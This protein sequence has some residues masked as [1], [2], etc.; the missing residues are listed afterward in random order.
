M[1]VVDLDIGK[2]SVHNE[3]IIYIYAIGSIL[4]VVNV[5]NMMISFLRSK[6]YEYFTVQEGTDRIIL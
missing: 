6:K 2:L 3:N 5:S 4:M 1:S